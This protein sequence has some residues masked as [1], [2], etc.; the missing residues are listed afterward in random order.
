VLVEPAN[1]ELI[2]LDLNRKLVFRRELVVDG[3]D[4]RTAAPTWRIFLKSRRS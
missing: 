2:F 3:V 1:D 4:L